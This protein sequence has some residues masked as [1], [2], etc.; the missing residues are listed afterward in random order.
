MNWYVEIE[1]FHGTSEWDILCEGLIMTF[2]LGD[3]FDNIDEVLQEVKA[4]IF[5]ILQDPLYLI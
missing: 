1:L 4:T 3:R 5:R 2:S